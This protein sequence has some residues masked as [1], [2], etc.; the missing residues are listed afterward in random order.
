MERIE[1]TLTSRL[2]K[3]MKIGDV[4]MLTVMRGAASWVQILFERS[5][6]A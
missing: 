2:I 6:A 3:I 4:N 1:W 5:Q